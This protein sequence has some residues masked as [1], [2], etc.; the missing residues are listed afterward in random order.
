MELSNTNEKKDFF[1]ENL[2]S[3]FQVNMDDR[4]SANPVGLLKF[5]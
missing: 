1:R 4:N 2:V 3:L 5:C